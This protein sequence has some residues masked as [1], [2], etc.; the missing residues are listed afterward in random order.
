[1]IALTSQVKFNMRNFASAIRYLPSQRCATLFLTDS[2][3]DE[4]YQEITN[5][6]GSVGIEINELKKCIVG[7][8]VDSRCSPAH[9]NEIIL[10]LLEVR[11][12]R[13]LFFLT[14]LITCQSCDVSDW[15]CSQ[16][17]VKECKKKEKD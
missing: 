10:F 16:G 6:I 17:E 2:E 1:M 14:I 13:I 8:S 3:K 12:M 7:V 4:F 15:G 5:F 9:Y 11:C